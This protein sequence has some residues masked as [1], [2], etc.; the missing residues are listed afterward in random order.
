MLFH[1]RFRASGASVFNLLYPSPSDWANFLSRLWRLNS[2][3]KADVPFFR[4]AL[5]SNIFDTASAHHEPLPLT[6]ATS[7]VP[8][9]PAD[10]GGRK[11][12]GE[13]EK[14]H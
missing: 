7:P 5:I 3:A 2:K 4:S 1:P 13:P 9:L 12:S 14:K 8:V 10:T 11:P 6:F